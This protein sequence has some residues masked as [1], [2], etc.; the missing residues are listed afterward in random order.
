M[1]SAFADL[2]QP[3]SVTVRSEHY[4]WEYVLGM[5]HLDLSNVLKNKKTQ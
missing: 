5:E 3:R 1:A 4:M 2:P